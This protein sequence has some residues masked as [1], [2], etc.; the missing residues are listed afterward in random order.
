MST[1][2]AGVAHH[3]LVW[4]ARKEYFLRTDKLNSKVLEAAEKVEYFFEEPK[5][6]FLGFLKEGKPWCISRERIWG[7]PLPIWACEKCGEQT[8]S[9]KQKRALRKRSG[10]Q[11]P[12]T[13]SCTSHG[14]TESRLNAKN[15]AE[16]CVEKTSFWTL[17]ITVA[18][19]H[20]RAS[21]TKNTRSLCQPTS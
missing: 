8:H 15:A 19:R 3:K 2:L 7:T 13:L 10:S 12:K 1:Q 14:L 6:R 4:L 20:T 11:F 18:L 16:P 5:N 17:G 21:P 9:W